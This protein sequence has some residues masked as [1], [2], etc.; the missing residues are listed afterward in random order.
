MLLVQR[1]GTLLEHAGGR[2]LPTLALAPACAGQALEN[3]L[4]SSV[5]A[6]LRQLV[7]QALALRT[8]V[9]VRLTHCDE[10]YEA[11]ATPVAAERAVCVLRPCLSA[12]YASGHRRRR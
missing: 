9:E 1:D 3:A 4:P 11:R 5:S 2:A 7:R 12:R 8:A 6:V 10:D